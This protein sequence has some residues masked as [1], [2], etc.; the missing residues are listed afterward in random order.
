MVDG[1]YVLDGPINN[2]FAHILNNELYVASR[3][4]GRLA[5]PVRVQAELYKGHEFIESENTSCLRAE[6][7][8]GATVVFCVTLCAAQNHLQQMEVVGTRGS[9]YW[10][11]SQRLVFRDARGVETALPYSKDT[12]GRTANC[13]RN[14]AEAVRTPSVALLT[15][16]EATR[17]F[18]LV[19]N[20][21]FESGRAARQVPPE[22]LVRG[23]EAGSEAVYVKDIEQIIDR[24]FRERKLFSELGVP[25]ASASRPFCTTGYR[26]FRLRW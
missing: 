16:V 11:F 24:A 9:A 26:E 4:P 13:L 5:N 18:T 15:P 19:V 17:A 12:A 10:E 1:E 7:D 2:P 22:F 25:W 3:E 21:A 6:L 14:I 8:N 23:A 20:A